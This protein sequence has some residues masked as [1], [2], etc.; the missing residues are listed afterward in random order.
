[1]SLDHVKISSIDLT[2]VPFDKTR[3]KRWSFPLRISLVNV[4]KSAVA[5]FTEEIL[6]VNFIFCAVK[7]T[8][9]V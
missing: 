7:V 2:A 4:T 3:N 9:F 1:M 8:E 6:N 5:T